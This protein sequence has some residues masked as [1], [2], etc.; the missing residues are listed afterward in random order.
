[1]IAAFTDPATPSAIHNALATADTEFIILTIVISIV[2]V[3]RVR[4][5]SAHVSKSSEPCQE[6]PVGGVGKGRRAAAQHQ[7]YP[8]GHHRKALDIIS[9]WQP[10]RSAQVSVCLYVCYHVQP[11]IVSGT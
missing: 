3:L 11:R 8:Y 5:C 2:G 1:M 9:Q 6:R 4:V 7:A 10:G